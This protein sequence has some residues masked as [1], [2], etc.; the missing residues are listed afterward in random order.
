MFSSYYGLTNDAA[1]ERL[2]AS[3]RPGGGTPTGTR[4]HHI[5][6]AYLGTLA[7]APGGPETIKPI[8]VIVVTDGIP[9]DDV[10]SVLV[11]AARK[12]DKLDTPSF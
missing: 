12:L 1:V 9:S 7:N 2:F 11:K 8:N 3:V 6:S 10:E 4:L 5:L